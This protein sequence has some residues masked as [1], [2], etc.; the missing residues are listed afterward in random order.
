[1]NVWTEMDSPVGALRLVSDG[2]ALTAV[3]FDPPE[4]AMGERDDEHPVLVRA[5]TQLGAYF[6]G[7]LKEFDLPLAATGTPFQLRVWQALREIGYGETVTYGEIA[8]R[9]G[10]A[11]GASRAV[12]LAN[13]RNPIAI[14]VPCHRVIGS[15]GRLVGY[16]GGLGRKERLL[17][18]ESAVLF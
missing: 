10:L 2:D 8:R 16:A 4:P 9:L 5:R 15:N 14:V 3:M 13:G 18:L 17:S 1:M 11:P 7:D 12:G 6:A